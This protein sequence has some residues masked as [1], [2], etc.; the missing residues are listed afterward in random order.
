MIL[1]LLPERMD[2]IVNSR[3]EGPGPL[4]GCDHCKV[5]RPEPDVAYY[6]IGYETHTVPA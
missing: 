3:A 4:M 6:L 5:S 1:E 2:S